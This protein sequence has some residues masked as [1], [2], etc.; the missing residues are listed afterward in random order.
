MCGGRGV[1][2]TGSTLLLKSKIL[3]A[4]QMKNCSPTWYTC[5]VFRPLIDS[6]TIKMPVAANLR[7]S[8]FKMEPHH[9][10]TPLNTV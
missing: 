3:Q 6:L 1:A 5:Y 2:V 9:H 7:S 8:E 4:L 10:M